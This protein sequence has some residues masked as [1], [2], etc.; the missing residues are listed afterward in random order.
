M[1]RTSNYILLEDKGKLID[2]VVTAIKQFRD[3][4]DLF[5]AAAAQSL[6]INETDLCCLT[7]LNDRGPLAANL[8]ADALG[9]T[10][11][12]T[13]TALNRME[14][15]G[16]LRRRSNA[17]DGRSFTIELT[18]GGRHRMKALWKP[19][20]TRGKKHLEGYS[21]RELQLLL[22]FFQQSIDLQQQCRETLEQ[23]I[24]GHVAATRTPAGPVRS[25]HRSKSGLRSIGV[26]AI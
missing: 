1:V 18:E 8:V 9:L 4:V 15:A 12:A 24:I 3:A 5:D 16:Y 7:T 20:R 6:G 2:V 10:R 23:D 22:S 19:M 26:R 21:L 25:A 14:Q 13:T 11:G 17:D